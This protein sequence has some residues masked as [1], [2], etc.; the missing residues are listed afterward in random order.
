MQ[1]RSFL[2]L[3]LSAAAASLLPLRLAHAE[4][5]EAADTSAL[6]YISPLNRQGGES[7]CQAEVWF[8]HHEG[9]LYVVTAASAWRAVA[10]GK[11]LSRARVWIG[12]V[13]PWKNSDGAYRALPAIQAAG[14]LVGDKSV[15]GAV[16]ARMGDKYSAEWRTW[17]PR[18]RDGLA[19]GSRVMLRYTP[20]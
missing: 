2:G 12:D 18:F 8:Q 16:L 10:V 17:G 20:V 5:P 9:A 1:R 15:H 6:I 11:G 4:L 13:G 19:D 3:S 14:S 7:S